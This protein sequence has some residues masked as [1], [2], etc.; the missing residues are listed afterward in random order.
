MTNSLLDKARG[1]AQQAVAGAQDALTAAQ[2]KLDE[3]SRA[4]QLDERLADL[5]AAFFAEQRTG[6][7]RTDV[8]IALQAVDA[9]VQEYGWS[10][11]EQP[12]APSNGDTSDET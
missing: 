8:D 5:G 6:G 4:S 12:T 2:H 9:H 3:L 1:A 11:G 7:T 10:R